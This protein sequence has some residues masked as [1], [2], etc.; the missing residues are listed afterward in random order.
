VHQYQI[1]NRSLF[2]AKSSYSTTIQA[3]MVTSNM[4]EEKL[5]LRIEKAQ[6]IGISPNQFNRLL[7]LIQSS[8]SSIQPTESREYKYTQIA[9]AIGSKCNEE[10]GGKWTC[11]CGHYNNEGEEKLEFS[12]SV[13]AIRFQCFIVNR[14]YFLYI[15]QIYDPLAPIAH[16]AAVD[17]EWV[18]I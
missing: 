18:S 12:F 5:P 8:F 10:F 7:P 2:F 3:T 17:N 6:G 9:F 15:G 1:G 14:E 16:V 11:V 13:S 4:K